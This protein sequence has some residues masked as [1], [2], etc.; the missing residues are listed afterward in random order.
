MAI[1]RAA[2]DGEQSTTS[3]VCEKS[4]LSSPTAYVTPATVT[5]RTGNKIRSRPFPREVLT[6][7][8]GWTGRKSNTHPATSP[9]S[10]SLTHVNGRKKFKQNPGLPPR[11]DSE[12]KRP[13]SLLA[14]PGNDSRL[15]IKGG[16]VQSPFTLPQ[17]GDSSSSPAPGQPGVMSTNK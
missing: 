8:N 4:K 7:V 5:V 2:S 9:L 6:R 1:T 11:Q 13:T 14:E 17:N 15:E 10:G 3:Q 16:G 12:N